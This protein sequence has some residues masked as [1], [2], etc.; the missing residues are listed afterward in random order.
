MMG[1]FSIKVPHRPP[2]EELNPGVGSVAKQCKPLR[3]RRQ[4]FPER[5]SVLLGAGELSPSTRG[6][7]GRGGL[8]CC[9]AGR[10]QVLAGSRRRFPGA[11]L[12]RDPFTGPAWATLRHCI[13]S[14]RGSQGLPPG[15][16]SG[17]RRAGHK[18]LG[19]G[20]GNL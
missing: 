9:Q 1:Y 20:P 18:M 19:S 13:L 14:T 17:P 8:V 16:G 6:W 3:R 5:F 12:P 4:T 10:G 7:A 11:G 15:H 2:G